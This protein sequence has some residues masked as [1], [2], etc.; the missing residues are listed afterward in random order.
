LADLSFCSSN[1][2]SIFFALSLVFATL[3]R[4]LAASSFAFSAEAFDSAILLFNRPSSTCLA[5]S[6]FEP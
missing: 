5:E 3:N 4:A 6:N 2:N 1:F